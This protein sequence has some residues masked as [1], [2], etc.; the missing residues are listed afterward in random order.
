MISNTSITQSEI[1]NE[2]KAYVNTL[3]N[4]QDLKD[5]LSASTLGTTYE[6]NAGIAAYERYHAGVTRRESCLATATADS[7]VFNLSKM[8]GYNISRATPPSI[9][10]K[11]NAVPTIY[12]T[13]G[14]IIGTYENMDIIYVGKARYIEKGD[15][16]D[17]VIGKFKSHQ[18][19]TNPANNSVSADITATELKYLSNYV[20]VRVGTREVEVTTMLEE[21]ITNNLIVDFSTSFTTTQLLISDTRSK[22]GIYEQLKYAQDISINYVETDGYLEVVF[23]SIKL[24]NAYLL[25]AILT[26][27]SDPDS[28]DKIKMLA[29]LYYTT[30]RR[31]VSIK[32]YNI[33]CR[34]HSLIKD[35]QV[36][37][38]IG[39]RGVWKF[40]A[41]NMPQASMI[42]SISFGA[43]YNYQVLVKEGETAEQ[44][45]DN[46]AKKIN[47]EE[48]FQARA[49]SQYLYVTNMDANQHFSPIAS[50]NLFGPVEVEVENVPP[51]CC[52]LELYY[53][54][55]TQKFGEE[56]QALTDTEKKLFG[57]Y[58]VEIKMAGTSILMSP[59]TC[60]LLTISLKVKLVNAGTKVG[61]T[62]IEDYVKNL[63]LKT[64]RDNYAHKLGAS[65]SKLEIVADL[66]QIKME[67]GSMPVESLEML[68]DF[69]ADVAQPEK[70]KYFDFE[71]DLEYV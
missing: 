21:F 60:Q 41:I 49:D 13:A 58:L 7:S 63:M 57:K 22:Y 34:A 64:L 2:I 30:L 3:D 56:A 42:V 20:N 19:R 11:Y 38:P 18:F 36:I 33:L 32:D 69:D 61:E 62:P 6:I 8:L 14:L 5:T 39:T 70:W 54:K 40:T 23:K 51:P 17:V 27:G 52:T 29:P 65:V 9:Q 55:S 35:V 28:I 71:F 15:L 16:I 24:G 10:V 46:L 37:Q 1:V 53:I 4:A 12:I 43:T 67:D 47:L 59:A 66:T 26:S 25:N 31:A 48:F 50:T 68:G 44:V 45:V